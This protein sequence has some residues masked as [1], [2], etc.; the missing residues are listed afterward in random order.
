[1]AGQELDEGFTVA[2][3]LALTTTSVHAMPKVISAVKS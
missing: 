2:G 1:M 3:T